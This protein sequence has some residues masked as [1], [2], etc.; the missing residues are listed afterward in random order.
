M[1]YITALAGSPLAA[2]RPAPATWA[3]M[4]WNRSSSSFGLVP[5][6]PLLPEGVS[7]PS[8]TWSAAFL[9]STSGSSRPASSFTFAS[10]ASF[11][12]S[13]FKCATGTP[14]PSTDPVVS[15]GAPAVPPGASP[16]TARASFERFPCR[17]SETSRLPKLSILFFRPSSLSTSFMLKSGRLLFDNPSPAKSSLSVPFCI[18]NLSKIFDFDSN[19]SSQA[20]VFSFTLAISAMRSDISFRSA[21][22]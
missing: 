12:S 7:P 14:T 5:G 8:C 2:C 10:I 4:G 16:S 11:A 20:S 3:A 6:G 13:S 21:S 9:P 17:R 22:A 19:I 18:R 15:T 1:R